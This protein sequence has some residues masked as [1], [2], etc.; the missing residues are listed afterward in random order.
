[1]IQGDAAQQLATGPIGYERAGVCG[2]SFLDTLTIPYYPRTSKYW[3]APYT[4]W[5]C[6][7]MFDGSVS[8]K[9]LMQVFEQLP[10]LLPNL[11]RCPVPWTPYVAG[12]FRLSCPISSRFAGRALRSINIVLSHFEPKCQGKR[13]IIEMPCPISCQFA[14]QIVFHLNSPTP[15]RAEQACRCT[16][17]LSML[18]SS[19][20]TTYTHSL[21]HRPSHSAKRSRSTALATSSNERQLISRSNVQLARSVNKIQAS[22]GDSFTHRFHFT[23][24]LASTSLFSG[25]L[26]LSAFA[27]N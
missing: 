21:R 1:V 6:E 9:N 18:S 11:R 17:E 24:F 2:L 25:C 13:M 12:N 10:V 7:P 22:T 3:L 8:P 5:V 23:S 20:V 19:R 27:D 26:R 16:G 4:S 14:E 15:S